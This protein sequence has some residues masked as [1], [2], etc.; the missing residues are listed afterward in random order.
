MY[1]YAST[2]QPGEYTYVQLSAQIQDST[3]IAEDYSLTLT[4]KSDNLSKIR[5]IPCTTEL[6]LNYKS[7]WWTYNYMYAYVTNNTNEPLFGIKIVF[8]LL[9]AEGNI[10]FVASDDLYSNRALTP[11]STMIFREDISSAFMDYF[12]AKGFEPLRV[13]AIAYVEE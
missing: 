9:D 11:G 5:R 6:K 12:K 3:K 4:G 7:G 10:L 2:L 8:A 1:S 13:D